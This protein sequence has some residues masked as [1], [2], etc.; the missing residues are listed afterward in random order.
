MQYSEEL[1]PTHP[2][3]ITIEFSVKMKHVLYLVK[4]IPLS[5]AVML[6]LR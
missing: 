1:K 3:K 6:G 2:M 5:I 4:A